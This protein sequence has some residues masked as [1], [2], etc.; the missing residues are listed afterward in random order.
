MG[1]MFEGKE[2]VRL[3]SFCTSTAKLQVSS[4]DAWSENAGDIMFRGWSFSPLKPKGHRG[5]V[6]ILS[7]LTQFKL[8]LDT[9]SILSP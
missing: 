8:E 2:N 1:N 7:D 5:S 3:L 4:W 6:V 9:T